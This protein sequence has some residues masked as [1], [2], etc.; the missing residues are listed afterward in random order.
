[1]ASADP[2]VSLSAP[3]VNW[4]ELR[5]TSSTGCTTRATTAQIGF[6]GQFGVDETKFRS[7]SR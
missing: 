2:P 3:L 5:I 7:G 6:A 4:A 1:V